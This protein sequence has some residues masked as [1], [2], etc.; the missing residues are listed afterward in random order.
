MTESNAKELMLCAKQEQIELF[1]TPMKASFVDICESLNV[2]RYKVRAKDRYNQELLFAISKT[3]KPC[4]ISSINYKSL[5]PVKNPHF[6]N[7][8]YDLKRPTK[9]QDT[10]MG[11]SN[12]L[13][14]DG[15]SIHCNKLLYVMMAML[16]P[17]I[18]YVEIHVSL[19]PSDTTLP[20]HYYSYG[21][22]DVLTLTHWRNILNAVSGERKRGKWELL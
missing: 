14:A 7:I 9:I 20:D 17:N 16:F 6:K 4:Y 5:D 1:F 13:K 18:E 21:F 8:Y 3:H 2:K 19:N 10:M 22:S 12:L 15:I 11:Y